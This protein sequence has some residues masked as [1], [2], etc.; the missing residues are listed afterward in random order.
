VYTLKLIPRKNGAAK[1]ASN[2]FLKSLKNF[3]PSNRISIKL[4][5]SFLLIV[6]FIVI[7]GV[8]SYKKSADSI[9]DIAVNSTIINMEQ[10]N[11]YIQVIYDSVE[12]LSL[13]FFTNVD[14]QNYFNKGLSG[15]TLYD[16]YAEKKAA[17]DS[18][19][20]LV[21]S[22]EFIENI[23]VLGFYADPI[24]YSSNSS[25]LF[26]FDMD[27][28]TKNSE[29]YKNTAEANGR[30]IWSGSHTY[31][32]E[33]AHMDNPNYAFAA[34]RLLRSVNASSGSSDILGILVIDIK[35]KVIN[36]VLKELN[37]GNSSHIFL[38]T[39]DNKVLSYAVNKNGEQIDS[40]ID[41][42]G[43]EFFEDIK[44][45]QNENGWDN[46]NAGGAKHLM[47]YSKVGNSGFLLVSLTPYA[48]LMAPTRAILIASVILVIIGAVC[49]VG[50]GL[51][52][53]MS[54]GR[55][56]K[57]MI[58][59][60]GLAAD[61]D[62]TVSISSARKD[63]LGILT[64]SIAS[65]MSNM[66]SL[67]D[68]VKEL[69][70]NVDKS[71]AVV[72]DTSVQVS[73]VSKEISH[74]VQEISQGASAQAS[75]A[76]QGSISM[77]VLAE[78]IASVVNSTKAIEKSSSDTMS[79]TE[80]GLLSV[81]DLEVKT[82]QTTSFTN[83][84]ISDIQ[85]LNA[86]S[87]S[88][89]KIIKVIS[90]IADQTNLLALN[91]TIEAARAG[92]AG[93]GFAVVADEVRKLAEQSM[94]AAREIGKIINDT[95]QMT[96]NAVDKAQKTESILSTQNQAVSDTIDVFKRISSSMKDMASQV[97][98]IM[99]KVTEINTN[100]DQ[101]LIAIQNIS[102]VSQQTAASAE[103]VTASTQEQLA[104]IEELSDFAK[105]LSEAAGKLMDAISRF[106]I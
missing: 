92:E 29:L 37:P 12:T 86:Q 32:D 48:E 8:V 49:A 47:T 69:A 61:G 22:N 96:S 102:A 58:S 60:A 16:Q 64:G 78:K 59:A 21:M 84:I 71:A 13:Q 33:C 85:K 82:T 104:S 24:I 83:E 88:I 23:F 43:M 39:P 74:A 35:Q 72:E 26:K 31:L 19:S 54:M 1:D 66:R 68:N 76:E 100:K 99:S 63:E 77:S 55:T 14:I 103:E 41:I 4:I 87:A 5:M 57:R 42:L 93:K 45:S 105:E 53:A 65:M 91:A 80:K 106:K 27:T 73:A 10:A 44:N 50:I 46:V 75:D 101:V 3:N 95:Q 20:G 28:Y 34:S 97:D 70:S 94:N 40:T 17:E 38:I 89:G 67:I 15:K 7:L 30:L 25:Y 36:D 18:V 56:I 11:N 81:E 6:V 52:M 2:K 79:L 62:L 90:G 9:E 51:Y 98:E